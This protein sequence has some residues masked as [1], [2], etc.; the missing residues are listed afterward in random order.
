MN[1]YIAVIDKGDDFILGVDFEAE[2]IC[3]VQKF[4][5]SRKDFVGELLA[6]FSIPPNTNAKLN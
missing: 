1:R 5:A 3:V 6:I 4:F 2:S